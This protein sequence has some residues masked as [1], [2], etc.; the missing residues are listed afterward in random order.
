M[1][2][3]SMFLDE[4]DRY[5]RL[6]LISWWEQEKIAGARI[7]VAGA[8]ALGNEVLKNLALLG[9]GRVFLLDFDDVENSNLSRSVLF[10]VD[11]EGQPKADCAARG[12]RDINGEIRVEA[13]KANVMTDIGLGI[14][15]EMN[16]VIG[17]LDNREARLWL[18]RSC[19]KV[20]VPW[21]DGGIQEIAGVV[22][23]F[24]PP[25]GS[26]YE[27]TMTEADYRL[28]NLRYSCPL[29]RREDLL[30]GKVPTAP[31]IASVI[32]GLQTQEAL[33]LLHGMD[34]FAGKGMVFSGMG[35]NFYTTAFPRKED[36]LSHE[37]YPDV[38]GL[39]LSAKDTSAESL[40]EAAAPHFKT[41]SSAPIKL[42]LDRD[43]LLHL[44]CQ[45]CDLHRQINRPLMT[46]SQKEGVC[47]GC[48]EDMIT[49]ITNEIRQDSETA[50]LTLA[51]AGIPPYDILRVTRGDESCFFCLEED[52]ATALG[53]V[54]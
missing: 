23:V 43:L 35:N 31:T 9:V 4:S 29:L 33:K 17:C 7:M 44:S 22:K 45:A 25:G 38:Q 42:V 15:R 53:E 51:E 3:D 5:S 6:R 19:W 40:F 28:I 50:K 20:N 2:D 1:A 36:C 12:L 47:T 24:M 26:C 27:C 48:G 10:R 30:Q 14:F 21:V 41:E 16:L 32:A 46:V 11:D 39:P 52:R 49:S 54:L 37:T 18:N 8:G 13:R 34:D